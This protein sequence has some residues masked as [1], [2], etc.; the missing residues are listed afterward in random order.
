[1][2]YRGA[3]WKLEGLKVRWDISKLNRRLSQINKKNYG[4]DVPFATKRDAENN[5]K[6]QRIAYN[7][8]SVRIVSALTKN[9][10]LERSDITEDVIDIYRLRAVLKR[11]LKK[12]KKG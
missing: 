7:D 10:S 12:Q 3:Q 1:M 9:T 4:D 11:E 5:L 2:S 8:S 6:L